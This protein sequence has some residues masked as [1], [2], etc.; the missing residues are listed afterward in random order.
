MGIRPHRGGRGAQGMT[1]TKQFS[2]QCGG[3]AGDGDK[4]PRR[5]TYSVSLV[6][7]HATAWCSGL[8]GTVYVL[9]EPEQASGP[10]PQPHV[11]ESP[12]EE[13]QQSP[14]PTVPPPKQ[15]AK[16]QKTLTAL[17]V[18]QTFFC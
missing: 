12:A 11:E 5:W 14:P 3:Q 15:G 16:N 4:L 13:S 2:G 1:E 9:Q 18:T 8:S 17:G 6:L 10:P 7:H